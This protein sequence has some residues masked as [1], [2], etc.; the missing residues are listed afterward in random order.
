MSSTSS[1][2]SV[3]PLDR[4]KDDNDQRLCATIAVLSASKRSCMMDIFCGVNI[5]GGASG[6]GGPVNWALG[7]KKEPS[8]VLSS[9]PVLSSVP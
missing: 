6:A 5:I 7:A 8:C 3:R 2:S 1:L 4:R 9:A